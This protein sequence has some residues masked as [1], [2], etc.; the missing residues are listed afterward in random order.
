MSQEMYF[1]LDKTVKFPLAPVT[2]MK[3]KECN[4]CCWRSIDN[5]KQTTKHQNVLPVYGDRGNK[6]LFGVSKSETYKSKQYKLVA[7]VRN[8]VINI[9]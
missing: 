1:C 6:Y 9:L 2:N 8:N 7:A 5:R 3:A 4:G